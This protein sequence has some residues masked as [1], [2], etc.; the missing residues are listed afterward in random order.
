MKQPEREF[1]TFQAAKICGVF[2]TTVINWVNKGKLNARLTPG[3]H[4]R[5]ALSD[6][7]AFMQAWDMP[8]PA[9]LMSRPKRV[10]V[11]EDDPAVQRMA[12]R[13]LQPLPDLEVQACASGLEALMLIGKEAPDLLL[14]DL[15]VPQ[16][17]GLEV[18][19]LISQSPHTQGVRIVAMTGMD[20]SRREEKTLA[21]MTEAILRKPFSPDRLKRLVLEQLD[22]QFP[23]EAS[24]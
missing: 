9:D 15:R 4:R 10:L 19:R 13:A 6:L 1:T 14:L 7:V 20:L 3:G 8:L 12:M 21:D 16:V 2:H 22:S 11:V 17:N 18:C 5:I 24:S 23:A